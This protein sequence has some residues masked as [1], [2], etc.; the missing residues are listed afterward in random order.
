MIVIYFLLKYT[1]GGR[2]PG[3][4]DP[5]EECGLLK[6]S[7]RSAVLPR[8]FP[9][10]G[11]ARAANSAGDTAPKNSLAKLIFH[12]EYFKEIVT[13]NPSFGKETGGKNRV[14]RGRHG[15]D[16]QVL[17]AYPAVLPRHVRVERIPRFGNRPAENA[18]VTGTHRVLVFQMG[19]QSVRRTINLA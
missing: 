2:L 9:L 16:R 8:G 13:F 3:V 10:V 4:R 14:K 1:W 5:P 15:D 12:F 18:S 6:S 19:P 7:R 11:E 17:G